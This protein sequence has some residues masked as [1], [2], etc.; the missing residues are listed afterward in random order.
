MKKAN[1]FLLIAI[2]IVSCNGQGF[3]NPKDV[4]KHYRE[5]TIKNQHGE[6]YENYL[7]SKSKKLATKDEFIQNSQ[8]EDNIQNIEQKIIAYPTDINKPTYRRFNVLSTTLSEKDTIKA[9]LY[10]TLINE[11]GNWKIIWTNTW[12]SFAD[13]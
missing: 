5:L 4:V 9:N 13:K 1:T 3:S 6:L 10:Y 7:S 12:L 11:N 8:T 2:T